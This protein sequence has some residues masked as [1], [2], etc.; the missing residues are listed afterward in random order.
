MLKSTSTAKFQ[1]AVTRRGK[2]GRPLKDHGKI[3]T[4][5]AGSAIIHKHIVPL[6]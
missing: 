3:L 5:M 6:T 1:A 2:C 4:I